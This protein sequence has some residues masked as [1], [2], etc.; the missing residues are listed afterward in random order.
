MSRPE[1]N[2]AAHP[3]EIRSLVGRARPLIDG[4]QSTILSIY[5]TSPESPD[6]AFLC[7]TRY[8]HLV[9]GGHRDGTVDV[10]VIVRDRRSGAERVLGTANATNHNGVN[11]VWINGR[12]LAWQQQYLHRLTVSDVVIG[13]TLFGPIKGE[14]PHKSFHGQ[15]YFTACNNRLLFPDP[16]REPF[17]EAEEGIYRLDCRSGA[18]QAVVSKRRIAD[19]FRK[20]YADLGPYESITILHLEPN[21]TGDRL[22]FDFRHLRASNGRKENL[23]GIVDA[24]GSNVRHIPV[25]PM[26]VVWDDEWS[27]L[28]VD[29]A[30]PDKRIY[31][32]SLDGRRLELLAGTATHVGVSP[33]RQWLVGEGGY[34]APEADGFTRVYLYARGSDQPLALLDEWRNDLVTWRW[35]AHVNPAFSSDGSR[36]Y[37]IRAHHDSERC[38]AVCMTL[39]D[40]FI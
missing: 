11:A 13:E 20:Q 15:L 9:R 12:C 4:E 17:V 27:M 36:L 10:D 21:A 34:Y 30:D 18:I 2:S 5:D 3:D 8:Q 28:G 7:Y 32:W 25:R 39:D 19:A 29:T 37:Y 33:D 26:H 24:D 40:I 35:V 38:Q 1:P 23:Q 31:R 22:L 16:T 14:L 6:G